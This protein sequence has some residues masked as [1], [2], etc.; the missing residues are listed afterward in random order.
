MSRRAGGR[1]RSG[2]RGRLYRVFERAVLG[3]GMTVVVWFV[4]RRLL[5]ALRKGSVERAPRTAG[6][7]VDFAEAG[8]VREGQL[9]TS[10][11]E[12]GDQTHG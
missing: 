12:V 4:E 11:H 7:A 2:H 3:L 1:R 5:K 9:S 10:P 8:P 6:E